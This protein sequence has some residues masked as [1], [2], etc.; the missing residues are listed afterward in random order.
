MRRPIAM[1]AG[2]RIGR[3]PPALSSGCERAAIGPDTVEVRARTEPQRL[4]E[5]LREPRRKRKPSA[6]RVVNEPAPAPEKPA[7]LSGRALRASARRRTREERVP[8]ARPDTFSARPDLR[9]IRPVVEWFGLELSG[10][11]VRSVAIRPRPRVVYGMFAS[12][13]PRPLARHLA[14]PARTSAS[15]PSWSPPSPSPTSG[16]RR[17]ASAAATPPTCRD[18]HRRN[19]RPRRRR[20]RQP[21]GRFP[22][23]TNQHRLTLPTAPA[24]SRPAPVGSHHPRS[25]RVPNPPTENGARSA[26]TPRGFPGHARSESRAPPRSVC[27]GARDAPCVPEAVREA[28]RAERQASTAIV[29]PRPPPTQRT[30]QAVRDRRGIDGVADL[31]GNTRSDL[32]HRSLARLDDA[33]ALGR[34]L[35]R[36]AQRQGR[37]ARHRRRSLRRGTHGSAR[38]HARTRSVRP[39]PEAPGSR[40]AGTG[41]GRARR[42]GR[43]SRVPVRARSA[44]A[45]SRPC[46]RSR[47]TARSPHWR[48]RCRFETSPMPS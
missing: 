23:T 19:R 38:L 42:R 44:R 13:L 4:R 40:D 36:E 34:G 6:D 45:G 26:S 46:P 47:T 30:P 10:R 12:H 29:P 48:S 28:R 35:L 9:F 39:R 21:L 2:D 3:A 31:P 43:R 17:P 18:P 20:P 22:Q 27:P 5:L 1:P 41:R 16:A 32:G 8:W 37:P 33:D 25:R 15:P 14:S 7:P 24:D 11:D